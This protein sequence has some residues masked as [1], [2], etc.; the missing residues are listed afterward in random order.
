[1]DFFITSTAN[2]EELYSYFILKDILFLGKKTN[3]GDFGQ[4][5]IPDLM[6]TD[7]EIGCEVT[8]CEKEKTF[9]FVRKLIGSLKKYNFDTSKLKFLCN[10]NLP[11]YNYA[12]VGKKQKFVYKAQTECESADKAEILREFEYVLTKKLKKLK[13]GNYRYPKNIYLI[14]L[15]DFA[16]KKVK[17][18][19]YKKIYDQI[20]T[21][22]K[23]K[24]DGV[25][26]T[27]NNKL[28]FISKEN[29]LTLV[30]NNKEFANLKKSLHYQN[31]QMEL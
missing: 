11:R 22:F 15:S 21:D 8:I 7:G 16:C 6:T 9:N 30:T 20:A 14:I 3:I 27:L 4:I 26:V 18:D 13:K 2:K 19:E 31:N 24:F 25:F 10:E 28:Y 5:G 17:I 29:N 1:M 23:K 12:N